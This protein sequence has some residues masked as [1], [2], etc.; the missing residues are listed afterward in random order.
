MTSGFGRPRTNE[1]RFL[2]DLEEF[3]GRFIPQDV[4]APHEGEV[5]VP[6][7]AYDE[8]FIRAAA[9]LIA[10]RMITGVAVQNAKSWR[11]AA[12][13]SFQS[14]RIY[15]ALRFEMGGP[16]G[17]RVSELINENAR[18]ISSLPDQA[19]RKTAEW[20]GAQ[21][22]RGLRASE[23]AQILERRLPEVT[24]SRI[25]L[26]ARTEV[27]KAETA[28]TQARSENLGITWYEWATSEDSRV[29]PAH[30]LLDRVLVA[31]NDAPAPEQLA[32]EQSYGHYH[33]GGI[34]NCRCIAL[35][36]VSVN[37]VQWPH[38]IYHRGRLFWITRPEFER[39]RLPAVA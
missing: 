15:E 30:R 39:L 38:K 13:R 16:V 14:R 29:R 22:R 37:E 24:Q 9:E 26:I 5:F 32:G 4:F 28:L 7:A 31:W 6:E 27:S 18:L 1:A 10:R 34:F 25:R 35:P 3:V 19:A 21:Q 17:V 23:I 2:R 33:A 8:A 36:L 11:E 12:R 20:I